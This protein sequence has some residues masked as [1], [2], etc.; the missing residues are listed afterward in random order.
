MLSG[1][2]KPDQY[3]QQ[4][5]SSVKGLNELLHKL[6]DADFSGRELEI[7]EA[8]QH[9]ERQLLQQTMTPHI[10]N[11]RGSTPKIETV[12]SDLKNERPDMIWGFFIAHASIDKE[13]AESLYDF[14]IQHSTVFLDSRCL[15]LG[16]DWDLE[17][18][19][20]QR[21]AR[22]T[23]VII[24]SQTEKAYYQREEIAAAIDM[25]RRDKEKHR[26][27]PIY[28]GEVD[29]NERGIP[30]GLRLK[31]SLYVKNKDDMVREA[32]KLLHLLADI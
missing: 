6:R 26:V 14:L 20:A 28:L 27:I 15:K 21:Q 5:I 24:S 22:A 9:K 3:I 4:H 23:I 7:F 2:T 12:E 17:I 25:A 31:H 19:H 8:I 11:F 32:P 30:Y 29:L 13:A 1:H 18:A 16:D 10:I